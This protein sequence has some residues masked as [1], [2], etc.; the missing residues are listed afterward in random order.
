MAGSQEEMYVYDELLLIDM[1]Y[2]EK[3]NINYGEI[4]TKNLPIN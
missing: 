3:N 1:W 2:E 4:N